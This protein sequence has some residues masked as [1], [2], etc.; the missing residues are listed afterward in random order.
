MEINMEK[1]SIKIAYSTGGL[2]FHPNHEPSSGWRAADDPGE[3]SKDEVGRAEG[4]GKD[5]VGRAEGGIV[6][7]RS[8]VRVL[9]RDVR[10]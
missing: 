10:S 2:G 1:E 6:L 5:G 9:F 8:S 4:I 3:V 7:G